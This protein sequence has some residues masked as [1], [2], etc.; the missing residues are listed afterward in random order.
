MCNYKLNDW[1]IPPTYEKHGVYCGSKSPE[2]LRF[3]QKAS[4]VFRSD[5][6]IEKKGFQLE[7]NVDQCGGDI[8][9]STMISTITDESSAGDVGSHNCV[10]NIT[11][12][13]DKKIV[14]RFESFSVEHS[15]YCVFD[16]VEI[17][18]GHSLDEEQRLA[19][20][21]GNLTNSLR[22]IVI[23]NN[24][25]VIQYKT[26][27]SNNMPGFSAAI[28]FKK[29]CDMEIVLTLENPDFL[30]DKTSDDLNEDQRECIYKVVAPPMN[31]IKMELLEM[32]LSLCAPERNQSGCSC[33]YLEVLDGNGPFSNPIGK[34]CG[35]SLPIPITSTNA[36]MYLR[37]VT[38]ATLSSTG[39]KVRFTAVASVCGFES[40]RTITEDTEFW[41]PGSDKN[42]PLYPANARCMW[43]AEALPTKILEIEFIYFEL[44]EDDNCTKDKLIIEDSTVKDVI[45]EGLGKDLVYR[46]KNYY[47]E[48]PNFYTG[49]NGPVSSHI[50]CGTGKPHQYVSQTNKVKIIFQ[51]NSENQFK[52]FK[53]KVSV[54]KACSRNFTSLQG[55]V[56]SSDDMGD[57][58]MTITV[59]ENYT[60]AIYFFKFFFYE[61]DC[62]KSFMKFYD[63][64]FESGALLR[65]ICGYNTPDPIFSTKS[66][67]SI[68]TKFENTTYNF[69]SKGNYDMMYVASDQGRGCGGEIYNYGGLFSSPLYPE[70]N[71]TR[72]NTDCTWIVSVPQNLKVAL[73][74]QGELYS[75]FLSKD[76]LNF[77]LFKN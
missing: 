54:V 52:G 6:W 57:C 46:G 39:F 15:D 2:K 59:P 69:Y 29:K 68:Y 55:R 19:K 64:D 37:Y 72:Q 22:P 67:V 38:D 5:R 7:Y 23:Q 13:S 71:T 12:P 66:R 51:T 77:L 26:D 28:M 47:S 8:K 40:H 65:T 34:Y 33:D 18:N 76:I 4:I 42:P 74:F 25:A 27:L 16:Y 49:I 20:L 63:G 11:A 45:T 53:M 17:F 36:A 50:Y 58:K 30:L 75:P 43:I 21:C 44:E 60:I 56:L 3:K 70:T 9:E 73:R 35:Y 10:W 24:L 48:R 14:I 41:S 1:M 62:A 32:H 61:Q 31:T